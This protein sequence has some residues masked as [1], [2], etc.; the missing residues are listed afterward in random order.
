MV[1]YVVFSILSF[2]R[3]LTRKFRITRK[4]SV[5]PESKIHIFTTQF[6]TA[7]EDNGVE[8]VTKWTANKNI[9]IF[10]K[11][12]IFIPINK[13]IHWSLCV[14]VNPGQI[15]NGEKI[16]NKDDFNENGNTTVEAPLLLFMDSLRVHNK[17]RVQKHIYDWLNSEAERLGKFKDSELKK[18]KLGLFNRSTMPLFDPPG[19]FR[20]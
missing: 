5:S 16:V 8:A 9:D 3:I 19:K 10:D 20:W 14:V 15:L 13:H 18:P 1:R 7:L 2:Y 4:E 11:K 17:I 6:F 12:F